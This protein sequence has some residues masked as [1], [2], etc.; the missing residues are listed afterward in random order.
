MMRWN[1]AFY[2]GATFMAITVLC[3]VA[4]VLL[5]QYWGIN[6]LHLFYDVVVYM[7]MFSILLCFPICIASIKPSKIR[8]LLGG[9]G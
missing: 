4:G 9:K 7:F 6:N 5:E 3:I 1:K 2:A 8:K